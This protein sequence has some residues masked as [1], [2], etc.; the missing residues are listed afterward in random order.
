MRSADRRPLLTR[1]EEQA[2][3]RRRDDARARGDEAEY[4]ALIAEL[5][6]RNVGLAASVARRYSVRGSDREDLLQVACLGL[7]RAAEKFEPER[8]FK[9][10]TC[11]TWWVRQALSRAVQDSGLIRAPAGRPRRRV[12]SL[13]AVLPGHEPD[14]H[15][16]PRLVDDRGPTAFDAAAAALLREGTQDVLGTLPP[17]ERE[18]LRLRFGLGG[19][20]GLTL[21]EVGQLLRV[22]R[23]RVRQLE[24]RALARL[25]RWSRARRLVG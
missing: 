12:A 6:E 21:E 17:R 19:T 11:A 14:D 8:G 5:V 25:R 1:A 16:A 24:Q 2:L 13:D 7:L 9:F 3:A 20:G 4:R 15:L 10:S 18:V 23:E 22:S